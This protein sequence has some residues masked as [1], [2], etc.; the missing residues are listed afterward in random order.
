MPIHPAIQDIIYR[1]ERT[2]FKFLSNALTAQ[3]GQGLALV[4]AGSQVQAL[5][6]STLRGRCVC[7]AIR[8]AA[9]A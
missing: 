2:L 9:A 7:L 3:S 5:I 4:V 8:C 1:G 6:E